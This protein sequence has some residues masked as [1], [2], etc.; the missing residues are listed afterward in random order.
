MELKLAQKTIQKNDEKRMSED[1]RYPEDGPGINDAGT[2]P[3]T[4]YPFNSGKLRQDTTH[5]FEIPSLLS[6]GKSFVSGHVI[7][8]ICISIIAFSQNRLPIELQT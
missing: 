6:G 8:S 5:I 2:A 3:W 7:V 4:P 1:T